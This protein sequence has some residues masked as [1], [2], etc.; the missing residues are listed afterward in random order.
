MKIINQKTVILTSITAL[1]LLMSVASHAQIFK[2]TD[3]KGQT[4]YTAQPPT[5]EQVKSDAENIE[6]E[7]K[8]N[9]GKSQAPPKGQVTAS[10]TNTPNSEKAKLAGPDPKLIKYCDSQ[11]DNLK[12]LQE[13]F[14]NVW[15]DEKG[16]RTQLDQDARKEKV[17]S[18]TT[19][20]KE[21]CSDVQPSPKDETAA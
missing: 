21:D 6:G 17:A 19:K 4:H 7:I 8:A 20:I 3:K 2:W 15:V 16:V 14:R 13:N 18:L 11:R 10:E 1:A 5:P 9:A 12:R